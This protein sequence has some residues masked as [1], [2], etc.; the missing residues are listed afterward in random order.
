[1]TILIAFVG[2]LATIYAVLPRER[3]LELR[4]RLT[5][6]DAVIAVVTFLLILDCEFYSFV[7]SHPFWGVALAW[8]ANKCPKDMTTSAAT[9]L[10]LLL[11]GAVVAAR[12]RLRRLSR[13]NIR[14]FR[15]LLDELYW[16]GG[17]EEIFNF[18]ERHGEML[19]RLGTSDFALARLRRWFRPSLSFRNL[20]IILMHDEL[21]KKSTVALNQGRITR[22]PWLNSIVRSATRWIQTNFVWSRMFLPNYSNSEVD[23]KAVIDGLFL[24]DPFILQMVRLRPYL[25]VSLIT[26]WKPRCHRTDFIHAYLWKLME[27][28][29]SILYTELRANQCIRSMHR[30]DLPENNRLLNFFLADAHVTEESNAYKPIGDY[31]LMLLDE[32]RQDPTADPYNRAMGY[33]IEHE[34]WKSPLYAVIRFFD[35]MVEEALHQNIEWHMWLYY[36]PPS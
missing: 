19:F 11:G 1:M 8:P 9:D 3:R 18:L 10:I 26:I 2:L 28:P 30:Y 12:M 20:E 4:L 13:R 5:A 17:Y 6:F 31:V 29:S 34:Q 15:K 14:K 21:Q 33:F 23:A 16:A 24:S 7:L 25:G 22:A 36:M 35:I 27:E 32:L